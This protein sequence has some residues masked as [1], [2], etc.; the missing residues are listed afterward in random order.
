[1][2]FLDIFGSKGL[3]GSVTDILKGA[4]ILKDPEAEFKAAQALMAFELETQK[5]F[6]TQM[7]SVNATMRE[8]AKSDHWLQW[9][10]RPVVGYTFSLTIINN[11]IIAPYFAKYG[12]LAVVIPGELWSAML[13]VLGVAAGTRGLEKWQK[14]K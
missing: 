4:G 9:S 3:V 5:A 13:V 10:W 6:T 2:G 14:A 12:V 11:Y 7:E 8:E 1:M